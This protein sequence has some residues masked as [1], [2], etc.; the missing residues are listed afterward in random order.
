LPEAAAVKIPKKSAQKA[1]I[2][3]RELALLN[4]KLKLQRQNDCLHI[5]LARA[6]TGKEL[7]ELKRS[8]PDL[9]ISEHEPFESSEKPAE[10]VDL[11]SVS[12]PP[13][14]LASLPHAID[15]IGDI[16]VVEVPPELEVYK[17]VIGEAVL[18]T[19]TRV[20][21]VLSK[22]GAVS[23]VF[24]LR[25]F[26][27]IGGEARTQTVHRE[28]GC[29]FHVDLEKAY[30]SPR[31]SY[32]HA[33]VASL[34]NEG[35]TI[36]DM[37]AGVGPFSVL[38]AK[39]HEDVNVYA[40]DMNPDAYGLLK[41]NVIVNRVID[42]VTPMLGDAR[43]VVNESLGG[44]A[45]RVIM[46]LPEKAV[47]YVDVACKALRPE[48]G[49]LNY[50]QFVNEPDPAEAAKSRLAEAVKQ[51][52]RRLHR[53]VQARIVRGVAPFTYQVVVDAEIK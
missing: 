15:F 45:D 13:N 12:L 1:L 37:F 24:R 5:P 8:V 44:V 36:I 31:L 30:F 39:K 25:T 21:T 38:I 49:I 2:S 40:I 35:E 20:K 41:K 27:L 10:L 11:L 29:I 22:W 32:E 46:N 9:V 7:E 52:D 18:K 16:A 43:Y 53:M 6:P 26:E 3:L 23:G 51:T 17:E 4:R 48:G 14:A 42:R 28:Y 19:H 47:E 50:Y 34:V 33:R